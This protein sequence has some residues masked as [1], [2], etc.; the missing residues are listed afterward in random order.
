MHSGIKTFIIIVASLSIWISYKSLE[1]H[2]AGPHFTSIDEWVSPDKWW[3]NLSEPISHF[4]Y[5]PVKPTMRETAISHL[6]TTSF[7]ELSSEQ[8][9][10]FGGRLMEE[11][12][13]CYLARG[14]A[15]SDDPDCIDV[16]RNGDKISVNLVATRPRGVS[17]VKWPVV[18]YTKCPISHCVVNITIWG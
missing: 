1:H 17:M 8:A 4:D 18:Y 11:G 16:W 9:L 13:L 6:Q 10:M 7:M 5:T 12:E 3:I 14:V 2:F 15:V